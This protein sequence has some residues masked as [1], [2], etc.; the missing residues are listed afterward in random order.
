MIIDHSVIEYNGSD[1]QIHKSNS[2]KFSNFL[3]KFKSP[4]SGL[5]N[6]KPSKFSLRK[7]FKRKSK[8]EV[9]QTDNNVDFSSGY[10]EC[11]IYNYLNKYKLSDLKGKQDFIV[12]SNKKYRLIYYKERNFHELSQQYINCT[13]LLIQQ[14]FLSKTREKLKMT[15]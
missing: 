4:S 2:F 8:E 7:F 11:I 6:E 14:T 10:G 9:N 3:N 5:K 1:K 13:I 12:S 15:R